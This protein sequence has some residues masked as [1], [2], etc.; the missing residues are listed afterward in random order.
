[1]LNSYPSIYNLGHA[2]I[3]DLLKSPVIVEEKVD[4]SQ[5]SFGVH[6]DTGELMCRSKGAVV[7]VALPEGMFKRGV[8][9][10][11][12]LKDRL[13]P[14]WTYRGEY[15]N[16]PSHNTLIYSRVPKKH[17]ILFDINTGLEQYATPDQKREEAERLG[18]ECV[19]V[20]YRGW[21]QDIQ[22]FRQLLEK[23]SVLG[24]QKIEGVVIKPENYALFGRDKKCLMGKFV[25]E[26]FKEAHVGAWKEKNPTGADA[27]A[28]LG[29]SLCTQ[30]RWMKAVQHMR[31]AGTLQN[32]PRDIG[33]LL[34]EIPAD[35][36][37]ECEQEIKDALFKWAWPH[38]R[39][40]AVKGFPEWYKEELV[41]K[42]F[43]QCPSC[44]QETDAFK[45]VA[46]SGQ[47]VCLPCH[48]QL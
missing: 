19:P 30:A 25:S 1:M 42:Q 12:E 16:S 6:K 46:T 29:A 5:F 27:I 31:E 3:E 34:K 47:N 11:L 8:E 45:Y 35:I 20:L 36:L 43:A 17:F 26:A 24:G 39:R 37:K 13:V 4:G 15:L 28:T 10:A 18:L 48:E 2:A 44:D 9:T 7:N 14:G 32:D 21:L 38:L 23:E 40:A 22:I 41:K 33:P